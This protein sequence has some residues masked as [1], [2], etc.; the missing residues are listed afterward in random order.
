[1][2]V[3]NVCVYK[4]KKHSDPKY[5]IKNSKCVYMAQSLWP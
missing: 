3:P 5:I 2:V 4:S 1:M